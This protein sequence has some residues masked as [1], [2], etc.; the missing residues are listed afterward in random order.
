MAAVKFCTYTCAQTNIFDHKALF[1]SSNLFEMLN[2]GKRQATRNRDTNDYLMEVRDVYECMD[3]K[4]NW[5]ANIENSPK[6][7]R[8]H[9]NSS[10]ILFAVLIF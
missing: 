3:G 8:N 10:K 9:L 5:L 7:D 4:G 6:S 2:L 1:S